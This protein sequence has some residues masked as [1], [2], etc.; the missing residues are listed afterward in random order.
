MELKNLKA[1]WECIRNEYENLPKDL[2][3][4]DTPRPTGVWEGSPVM[5]EV[6]SKYANGGCGWLKGGQDHVQDSWISWPLIWEGTPIPGNCS[7]C[8]KT[9]ELL[10]NIR[11][12]VHIAG[13]SLM[14]GGVKLDKHVD[15]V[16]KNYNFTYH[17]GLKCP[18]GST[19]YHDTMGNISEEDGKHLVFSARVPHWAENT[20]NED[21][22]ILYM[23][24][25]SPEKSTL[26]GDVEAT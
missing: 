7:M 2:F 6:I 22:I 5:N 10:S 24:F 26:G 16:G 1:Y 9:S 18:P 11:P 17:L 8:P 15:H 20:S 25:Y 19:L 12:R 4:S 23:E 13:F 14:K 3:I 21:R